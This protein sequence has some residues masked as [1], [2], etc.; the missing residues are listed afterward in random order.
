M[1]D[2]TKEKF[3][4]CFDKIIEN[5]SIDGIERI[6]LI[7]LHMANVPD[8]GDS[9]YYLRRIP[10]LEK[11]L[12][13]RIVTLIYKT[14]EE[15]LKSRLSLLQYDEYEYLFDYIDEEI[16]HSEVKQMVRDL[17]YN[18]KDKIFTKIPS[19]DKVLQLGFFR[20]RLKKGE[21]KSEL[22]EPKFQKFNKEEYIE[23]YGIIPNKTFLIVP[24][25]RWAIAFPKHYWEMIGFFLGDLGYKVLF[26][27]N[28]KYASGKSIF[29]PFEDLTP[30][31][32]L[33]GYTIGVKTG[34]YDFTIE[35]KAKFY[36]YA[37]NADPVSQMINDYI[38]DNTDNHIVEINYKSR[39]TYTKLPIFQYAARINENFVEFVFRLCLEK[40]D[41]CIFI[42]SKDA[43]C[44]STPNKRN[45]RL[46][47]LNE[48][49]RLKFDFEKSFRWSY[50][51]VI[52]KG[53]VVEKSSVNERVNINYRNNDFFAVLESE[54][55]NVSKSG[56]ININIK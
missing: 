27:S 29:A 5:S 17:N 42:V 8:N 35:A 24:H 37:N 2:I 33:C 34:F 22:R 53:E 23:K 12:N 51:A 39:S 1:E 18:Y 4:K 45:E 48:L 19:E 25:T 47:C 32:E 11:K 31:V 43:H 20:H 54:G 10:I 55:Y 46:R 56:E 49:L 36:L 9:W 6:G 30:L 3:N 40:K 38:I 13:K 41:L 28:E 15:K 7:T 50:C 44:N 21:K 52:D 26:N 14:K 16:T